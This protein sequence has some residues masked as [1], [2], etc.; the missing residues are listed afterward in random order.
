MELQGGLDWSD[1]KDTHGAWLLVQELLL[2]PGLTV[3]TAGIFRPVLLR[4]VDSLVRRLEGQHGR[5]GRSAPSGDARLQAGEG[6]DLG[7]H[8]QTC[9]ALSLLLELSPQLMGSVASY[10]AFAP[11]PF[12][13]LM[14]ATPGH[15]PPVPPK[16]QVSLLEVAQASLRLLLL[17]PA[18][19]SERWDWSPFLDLLL[20]PGSRPA[21]AASSGVNGNSDSGSGSLSEEAQ[22]VRWCAV[23]A[24]GVALRM[25]EAAVQ[26][27][28]GATAGLSDQD[29]LRCYLRWQ[30]KS[31]EV[32]VERA[33][34]FLDPCLDPI[35]RNDRSTSTSDHD[36]ANGTVVSQRGARWQPVGGEGD[37]HVVVCGIEL[38]RREGSV[39]RA[40]TPGSVPLV[41]TPTTVKNLEAV[42]LGLC[43]KRP[44]LLEGPAGAGK[45]TL[46]DEAAR[47]TGNHDIM[48]IH[49]DD[50]MDSKT[51]LGSY[52]CTEVPGEFQWQPGALTQAVTRGVWVVFEDI[53]MAPFE[54]LSALVPILEDRRL[55]IPGRG[56]VIEAAANFQLFGTRTCTPQGAF[57]SSSSGAKDILSNLWA[58]VTID[59]PPDD[60]LA[61]IMAA[62]FPTLATLIPTMIETLNFMRGLT[63]DP[64][65]AA[66]ARSMGPIR[67]GRQFSTRD[68]MKW[69]KRVALMG[70]AVVTR[71]PLP[72]AARERIFLEAVDC[73]VGSVPKLPE[74]RHVSEALAHHW[75]V[76]VDRVEFH[77]ALHKPQL[78][79]TPSVTHVG[80]AS[81]QVRQQETFGR[82][83]TKTGGVFAHTGHVARIMERL[84]MCVQLSEPILLV[85]ETGTGKTAVVQHLARLVNTPLTVLNMSQQTDSADFLGGFKPVE[86]QAVCAPLLELFPS[87]FRHTFPA[88]QNTEFLVRIQRFAEKKK[89]AQLLKA[90][91]LAV[92]RVAK[93]LSC[94]PLSSPGADSPPSPAQLP[95]KK[96]AASP[97]ADGAPS[98]KRSRQLD[99]EVAEEWRKFSVS[100]ARAERQVE[101][102]ENAFAFS[103]IEGALV[104][105]LREGQ[106]LLLDEINLAPAET[107]ERLSGVLEGVTGSIC[108]TEKGDVQMVPR[109]PEFRLFAAMNPATDVGK[110]DL[111]GPLKNR[112][113]EFYVDEL[114]DRNDLTALV[115]QYLEGSSMSPPVDDIVDF[116]LAA[117]HEAEVS[118]LDGANQRPR[119][120][121]RTLSR[122]LEY[123]RAGTPVYGLQRSLHDAFCMC[124]LTLLEVYAKRQVEVMRDLQRARQ[125]SAVFAGKHGFIT[126]RHLFRWALRHG[127]G[128]DELARDGYYILGE[129]LRDDAEKALVQKALEQRLRV[130]LDTRSLHD[131]RATERF[132]ELQQAM[133]TPEA[134]AAFG[135][136]VW[137]NSMMRLFN[138]VDRCL[139][140]SEPVLLVGETGCGKTTVCQ[141]AALLM[142]QRL[143]VINCHQHTETSDFLGG[144]RPVRDRDRTCAR[145]ATVVADV[146]AGD[147]FQVSGVADAQLSKEMQDAPDAIAV[148]HLAVQRLK[149]CQQEKAQPWGP[150]PEEL[151]SLPAQHDALPLGGSSDDASA[152]SDDVSMDEGKA[153]ELPPEISAEIAR[154]E[155]ALDRQLEAL[156]GSEAEMRRLLASW[157]ALFAWHDGP[158]MTAMKGGN[159]F[160]IDEI[161]LAEDSVLER[162]NSVL[163]PQRQLV[164]AEKGGAEV[165][166]VTAHPAFR[167]LATMNPG[168]DF[169]KKEL[170]PALRNRFTEIWVPPIVDMEDLRSIVVDRECV[171][172]RCVRQWF[173]RQGGGTKVLSVRDLLAWVA[174]INSAAASLG[175]YC[176]YIH[177]AFL[178][179][180][181]GIGLGLG[182]SMEAAQRTRDLCFA[183][184]LRQLPEAERAPVERSCAASKKPPAAATLA[185]LPAGGA[186]EAGNGN[187][188][189]IDGEEGGGPGAEETREGYFG[190]APFFIPRGPHAKEGARFELTAPTTGRNA[191]R[192]LRALQLAKPVAAL[193]AQSGHNLVRINLS[194][195]TDMMDLLGSDLPVEG[196]RGGDFRWSNGVFLQALEAGDW[197]LLD[198]LNLA[199]QSILEG[200]NACLDH[201]GEVF[202][203]ELGKTFRCPPTFRIFACQNPLQQGGGRKGLPKSFL[204]RFTKVYVE[205]LE[206]SDLLFIARALHP[207]I[208]VRALS[209]MIAFNERMRVD[210]MVARRFGHAGAP[211]EFNL[212]DVLRWCELISTDPPHS[213]GVGSE[214]LPENPGRYLDMVYLQRMRT[215]ADRRHVRALYTEIFCCPPDVNP[216]PHIELSPGAV[217]VG[218]TVSVR[219]ASPESFSCPS[220]PGSSNMEL[221]PGYRNAL[222]NALQCVNRGW[223]CIL[224]GGPSSG[225]ST[226][227]RTLA[228]L[229]GNPL[230]E[231]ALTSGTDT[232]DLLGCFEQHDPF[233]KLRE[234][235]AL[236]AR[237]L[238]ATCACLLA[239]A[240]GAGQQPPSTASWRRVQLA[241]NVQ[242]T[243][244]MYKTL[245]GG[246]RE[247][248][249]AISSGGDTSTCTG[250]GKEPVENSAPAVTPAVSPA[251]VELLLQVVNQLESARKE[252]GLPA[253]AGH[254]AP[255]GLA[256]ELASMRASGAGGR[257]VGRFEWVDGA[258]LRALERGE[259]VLLD[260]ANFC[261]PTVLD[262]LNPLMEPGGTIMINERGLVGGQAMVVRA[263]PNF[264]LFL[265][266]DAHYGEVSRAMRNRGTE[267]FM[268]PPAAPPP[269]APPAGGELSLSIAAAPGGHPAGQTG[270]ALALLR[271]A[272]LPG[273]GLAEAMCE[274]H[275]E[276]RALAQ[277]TYASA[278]VSLREL[279]QW[280]RLLMELMER[281]SSL[282]A[283]LAASWEQTYV[284]RLESR[285]A[286]ALAQAIFE[287]HVLSR[288]W[289]ILTGAG[290]GGGDGDGGDLTADWT[291][292]ALLLPGGWPLPVDFSLLVS[293]SRT[294]VALAAAAY[295]RFLGGQML[296]NEMAREWQK[297]QEQPQAQARGQG[298]QVALSAWLRSKPAL[299]PYLPVDFLRQLLAVNRSALPGSTTQEPES[300]PNADDAHTEMEGVTNSKLGETRNELAM[301]G[302]G[303]LEVVVEKAYRP[304]D[305]EFMLQVA[306]LCAVERATAHDIRL[307]VEALGAM[308]RVPAAEQARPMRA[309]R[310]IEQA[311]A[312]ELQHPI[313]SGLVSA[314]EELQARLAL[315]G[316]ASTLRPLL[317][318]VD[319]LLAARYADF[320]QDHQG[321]EMAAMEHT[322]RTAGALAGALT[323]LRQFL[324][325]AEVEDEML[326]SAESGDKSASG[327]P[328]GQSYLHYTRP[329]ERSRGGHLAHRAIAWLHPLFSALRAFEGAVLLTSL[330]AEPEPVWTE[331]VHTACGS[332]LEWHRCLWGLTLGPSL[333][334]EALLYT[335]RCLKKSLRTFAEVAG[336]AVTMLPDVAQIGERLQQVVSML[337]EALGLAQGPPGKPLLWTHG[338]HP[339]MPPTLELCK[340]EARLI[341]MCDSLALLEARLHAARDALSPADTCHL[342]PLLSEGD[343]NEQ[344]QLPG[345]KLLGRNKQAP[346]R[347]LLSW[348]G[349]LRW[350][351]AR[352]LWLQ[353]LPLL[354][355]DSVKRDQGLLVKLT[356]LVVGAAAGKRQKARDLRRRLEEA[357][358]AEALESAL[359]ST[360]RSPADF[361]PHQQLL[362]LADADSLNSAAD[363][364]LDLQG[365]LPCLLHDMWHRWHAAT[366]HS[367]TGPFPAALTDKPRRKTGE[368]GAALAGA[369]AAT[370]Q[371]MGGPARMLHASRTTLCAALTAGPGGAVG[372]HVPR[373]MQLQ[374][375]ARHLWSASSRE[376]EDSASAEWTSA[377][378]L[379]QQIV[380]A[381]RSSYA[382]DK[383]QAIQGTLQTLHA[384]GCQLAALIPPLVKP[385]VEALYKSTKACSSD[386]SGQLARG[387]AWLLIG[388]LRLHLVLP[389]DGVDPAAKY[390]LK[391]HHLA[392]KMSR[393]LLEIQVRRRVEE[394][395][396]GAHSTSEI[397]SLERQVASL[398][399]EIERLS[400]KI[401]PRP[402]PPQFHALFEEVSRFLAATASVNRVLALAEQVSHSQGATWQEVL[403]QALSWQDLLVHFAERLS[404]QYPLYH[405]VVQPVQLALYEVAYGARMMTAGRVMADRESWAAPLHGLLST[406]MEYPRM[407]PVAACVWDHSSALAMPPGTAA[408]MVDSSVHQALV[409]LP[410]M[411]SPGGGG[412]SSH[413]EVTAVTDMKVAV[414]R[415]ALQ[416]VSAEIGQSRIAS[417]ATLDV[418]DS[419]LGALVA[420]WS[421]MRER[422][423]AAEREREA[424]FRHKVQTHVIEG[425]DE[426][427][428]ADYQA[429]F[430]DHHREFADLD[431]K[432]FVSAEEEDARAKAAEEEEA[433]RL[434]AESAEA[435]EVP[436]V[437]SSRAWNLLQ[438]ELLREVVQVHCQLSA[439]QHQLINNVASA[440]PSA[441]GKMNASFDIYK[442]PKPAE[443]AVMLPPMS[444]LLTRI[445]V[446]LEEWPDHPVLLSLVNI[447]R[448]VLSLPAA[449][450]P[451]VKALVG[452]E[453]LLEKA[454][455]WEENA[456]R[457][458]SIA[459]ELDGLARLVTRWRK[460]ELASWPGLLQSTWRTHIQGAEEMWYVLHGL[461][462]RPLSE[463]ADADIEATTSSLEEFVQASTCGQ[464]GRRLD[465][466]AAFHCHLSLREATAVTKSPERRK[467]AAV[468]FNM[469]RYYLQFA[470]TVE[471]TLRAGQ[472]PIEKELREFVRLAKWEDRNHYAMAASAD[473]AHRK[474]HKLSRKFAEIL[475]QPI[476]PVLTR[477]A[478]QMG[479]SEL[480]ELRQ[481][482][483]S[484]SPLQDL[485][486]QLPGALPPASKG[487]AGKRASRTW[488]RRQAAMDFCRAEA[489]QHQRAVP[490]ELLGSAVV[491][492][493]AATSAQSTAVPANLSPLVAAAFQL[494]DARLYRN[495]LPALT[496]RMA[497]LLAASALAPTGVQARAEGALALQDIGATILE[498]AH[499][500]RAGKRPRAQKKKA[501]V[502]LLK[503]LRAIGLSH[504]KSAIV[505]EERS[506]KSWFL[507][508]PP[509]VE[510]LLCATSSASADVAAAPDSGQLEMGHVAD[511]CAAT[512]H[513]ADGYYYKNMAQVQRMW[514]AAL[515]FSK[516]LSLREVEVSGRYT[517]HLLQWQRTQRKQA[518][519]FACHLGTLSDLSSL[520][521][522]LG[523][524]GGFDS[525]RLPPQGATRAWMWRQKALLDSLT[526][527]LTEQQTLLA[528]ADKAGACQAQVDTQLVPPGDSLASRDANKWPLLV[529]PRMAEGVDHVFAKV[530]ELHSLLSASLELR[531][532]EEEEDKTG[533]GAGSAELVAPGWCTT[534]RMF[535]QAEKMREAYKA[536]V[537]SVASGGP[538]ALTQPSAGAPLEEEEKVAAFTA[539]Y[540]SAVSKILLAVQG[541]SQVVP[542]ERQVAATAADADAFQNGQVVVE[543]GEDDDGGDH[544]TDVDANAEQ[545]DADLLATEGTLE[546]WGQAV[547]E[548]VDALQVARICA[549][550][551]KAILTAV[552]FVDGPSPGGAQAVALM[553]HLMGRLHIA[554][555]MIRGVGL[556][557]LTDHLAF[558]KEVA[559]LG[560]I[561]GNLFSA[562]YKE[563]FCTPREEEVGGEGATKFNDDVSG[564]GMGEGEGKKDEEEA[565]KAEAGEKQKEKEK[566]PKGVEM[567]E[568]FEGELFDLSDDDKEEEEEE[569]KEGEEEE[570]EEE[571]QLDQEMGD[572]G[573]DAEVVD[574]RLWGE[575][576]EKEEKEKGQKEKEKF[577]KDA[578]VSGV[579]ED[580]VEYR[581]KEEEEEGA[582]EGEKGKEGKEKEKEKKCMGKKESEEEEAGGDAEEGK[583]ED[584][585]AEKRGEDA[586]GEE[587]ED[588]NGPMTEESHGIKPHAEEDME[589]PE[590]MELDK[591]EGEGGEEEE[592]GGEDKEGDEG[593]G[594]GEEEKKGPRRDEGEAGED[595]DLKKQEGEE[596]EGGDVD[597]EEGGEQEGLLE[598]DSDKQKAEEEGEEEGAEAGAGGAQAEE[599]EKEE[600]AGEMTGV[601]AEEKQKQE[602]PPGDAGVDEAE[603]DLQGERSKGRGAEE[604]QAVGMKGGPRGVENMRSEQ[605]EREKQEAVPTAEA[606]RGQSEQDPEQMTADERAGVERAPASEAEEARK[607]GPK[608]SGKK[609]QE[610]NPYRSLGDALR[611]WKERV[612]MV[613]DNA[614]EGEEQEQE[615]EKGGKEGGADDEPQ[616]RGEVGDRDMEYEFVGKEEGG[617]EQ[618]LGAATDDQL[619]E[620]METEGEGGKENPQEEAAAGE[621][622]E[623]QEKE[624]GM[625]DERGGE[626]EDEG[627][628]NEGGRK[629]R[630]VA[631]ARGLQL[632]AESEEE[633]EEEEGVG[634]L[635]EEEEEEGK[636][637]EGIEEEAEARKKMEAESF[638][639]MMMQKQA[640]LEDAEEG[641]EGEEEADQHSRRARESGK[642]G[643]EKEEREQEKALTEEELRRIREEL[644]E[645]M[646]GLQEEEEEGE[647]EEKRE[648]RMG[649]AR[650]AWQRYEA[651]TGQ[652][653]PYIAS[654][655]RKDKIWLRRTKAD[656]R[657]YQV[658]LAIDD[659]RSMSESR[660]GHLALE[661]MAA[662]CRAM[663]QLEVGEM[664]VV[665]FG[666]R[667]NVRQ[668]HAFDEPFTAEAGVEVVSQFSFK[669]DNTIADEPVVELL[670]FLTNM[671]ED[672]AQKV[673]SSAGGTA[674]LQQLVLIIADGR[675]H[676]KESL[677]R[678]IREAMSRRQLV[679]FI[680]LDNP[681]ES[682]LD[683]QSVSFTGGAPKFTKYLDT[684]PFPYYILLRDIGALPQTLANLLRQWFELMQ[685]M[686]TY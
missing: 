618:A 25:S 654:Q 194:E 169:G 478:A 648:R 21:S 608:K 56:E 212:R 673:G 482:A 160:L 590:D 79:A 151:Q 287:R 561:L 51:L 300:K 267:I 11:P 165:E 214:A 48:K 104:K 97:S 312:K 635:E 384:H 373:S 266:L 36:S 268:L 628:E 181:D 644:E 679:A 271:L 354:D 601:T 367:T 229:T 40:H 521:G 122:A 550:V 12:E 225:K 634:R 124:F 302:R 587:E 291:R 641:G 58:R 495:R 286:R 379:F 325:H 94:P 515:D 652:V 437:T 210:T 554:L 327:T 216:H 424:L 549:S 519:A 626:K 351:S 602:V 570:K 49:L 620:A 75:G 254:L 15:A 340:L 621:E 469:R 637:G 650:E 622:E 85:G 662:I 555:E 222:E 509:R 180:L 203:P 402:S 339:L 364:P 538:T 297:L 45:S 441:A 366:W 91:R 337:D 452:V 190:I 391:Q 508:P 301:T 458:V 392:D 31:Q 16:G 59:A 22:D 439:R 564:T 372:D 321:A 322:W 252:C 205:A 671:L 357:D 666:E 653:I 121:L 283:G 193:A 568:D 47:L 376:A 274:A 533:E 44:L 399:A 461:V 511:A 186:G 552:D 678:C 465:M 288:G 23:R 326:T 633:E 247:G 64:A 609:R 522:S 237:S 329:R 486:N 129:R 204:N 290:L 310:R 245:R 684:F 162:L 387:K 95:K 223:M 108:L 130:Q 57:H 460:L 136:I 571:Q 558:H 639:S 569:G 170:S 440:T 596:E 624:G 87:L 450:T 202:I 2:R 669:Q 176:A 294:G 489:T 112:F 226:L 218:R 5:A 589:L 134:Q 429:M 420:L 113:T 333:D 355:H 598:E 41:M 96:A 619:A 33:R 606:E 183:Y 686:A 231:Y 251:V 580:Q 542:K 118:L 493:C 201:R 195:Q 499:A 655:F 278:T 295:A 158:L 120:S 293:D 304:K 298:S 438:K 428:E 390:A 548:Q 572:L 664:A 164:L 29:S 81:M 255:A 484:A 168:G 447:A 577:E 334:F 405:D 314:N 296:A 661:A 324:L 474:L 362:W 677:K 445:G 150:L 594:E 586:E 27:M 417:C 442:D 276:L 503:L 488:R 331:P 597:M 397:D 593:E 604:E 303:G 98:P 65:H 53:D 566:Q 138:L 665:G 128:Y 62:S 431:E 66:H 347:G 540:E 681:E 330:Q 480:S 643:E 529:T 414:L 182:L 444:A 419:V 611:K 219:N 126:A 393:I 346:K 192:V 613:G 591:E 262:R 50:Q 403:Q 477:H 490:S 179:L 213:P 353:L 631:S 102:A 422:Q 341:A 467:L 184:L 52:V 125:S 145:Y 71:Q 250:A 556:Q 143:H 336:G 506:P 249:Q 299:A 73:F 153:P 132:R 345:T 103:F 224:V 306:A 377:S 476:M 448:R 498:R 191:M 133:A 343:D 63:G 530:R 137:T 672:A 105:A 159:L 395:A 277:S 553:G 546:T 532:G 69:S 111:P 426:M 657:Q 588:D 17:D 90:F 361:A 501:L 531:K 88:Q 6:W 305:A 464:F 242:G 536:Q 627:K 646:R 78:Q 1:G 388:V 663:A 408:S 430:P 660:C 119:Y 516:D 211:W 148:V 451:V 527:V 435:S 514:Q 562:L 284:R 82:G 349:L 285:E 99:F 239:P 282:G 243:W 147:L 472:A 308:G 668:V 315:P 599:E 651:L 416:R 68:L 39:G 317:C 232:T 177:G 38:P 3:A 565:P 363:L 415:V 154:R 109:H 215:A 107:L 307:R 636:E 261:N 240:G 234:V 545:D 253:L 37:S 520:L 623:A 76:P 60:E 401:V 487:A 149:T 236:V 406:L 9:V 539:A 491:Q 369:Q 152:P 115:I 228:R 642:G 292:L 221:L 518:S 614:A 350:E 189:E 34:M 258:L 583:G 35:L 279:A 273:A 595:K 683:M 432:E 455:V 563:G 332:V 507:Q 504:H 323:M 67:I 680:V 502:D 573:E 24:T 344:L 630:Q 378:L 658:V 454:Q 517:E 227:V 188:M 163:E 436:D 272:G 380:E 656:K 257:Q 260:N 675:F 200:L 615:E 605:R 8:E 584:E 547:S 270:D 505:K 371:A 413:D 526:Q 492:W 607:Q 269:A 196:G 404:Q 685:H 19:M 61:S 156:E 320:V 358:V 647:A 659:S 582:G 462:F 352:A 382:A 172:A 173:Q 418:L 43:Q 316:V 106:W 28:R 610:A 485:T 616:E 617:G 144:F 523:A 161:S 30:A 360:S 543:G 141:M 275:E 535:A 309:M 494:G 171:L 625:E 381:H 475:K 649:R 676:E 140:H 425:E 319:A 18:A 396:T 197:V 26:G 74:R 466:L 434:E 629:K 185:V 289:E 423:L 246:G 127:T 557:L 386:T 374:L 541:L 528:V 551:Q 83:S 318:Q 328:I 100:L 342:I 682:I 411:V 335:W 446:L 470:P 348:G 46:I 248:G 93:L 368:D 142:R 32:A 513:K 238:D 131:I 10:F 92:G 394:L 235:E 585:D 510:Q 574:E 483:A 146:E 359:L 559:K 375:A 178:V 230:H 220:G 579:D 114:T 72:P 638:V 640:S 453:L 537:K 4:L 459:G 55:Y 101:A 338:G 600:G 42:V 155:E 612:N 632:D 534:C 241:K 473:K 187:G 77:L 544:K 670:R 525:C 256:A 89:W 209:R 14:A 400:A 497:A 20:Y 512:W 7:R 263:H 198:E 567:Q 199:S 468:L 581:G 412:G 207:R 157:Q 54:V 175:V 421:A 481:V 86:T 592:E 13:R 80:R 365:L 449:S 456:A 70:P 313:F 233:R 645:R 217:Q 383:W 110:R 117:R 166:E 311:L 433:A 206:A 398:R 84:G 496:Q 576:D 208:G 457:H 281:G 370:W 427:H 667:G 560:Y 389:S 244:T 603:V 139:Q 407:P 471:E 356:F 280:V 463:N 575:E 135:K 123:A 174:Y 674:H 409:A 385:L 524:T 167:I 443:L 116:Y 500:L 410:R 264:R 578:P 265:T 259:W 479:S